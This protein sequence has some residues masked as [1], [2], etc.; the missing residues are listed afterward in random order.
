MDKKF[1]SVGIAFVFLGILLGAFA[2]HGL[3]G[4]GID[5]DGIDSFEVGVRYLVITGISFLALAGITEKFDFELKLNFRSIMWGTILFSGS[6]FILVLSPPLFDVSLTK[7][8]WFVTPFGG[9]IMILGWFTLFVKHIRN[10][11]SR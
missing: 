10:V 7:Y 6:I 2:S 4:M 3:K 1:I 11:L 9:L 5:A 8:L